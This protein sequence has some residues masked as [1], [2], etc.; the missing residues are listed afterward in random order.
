MAQSNARS[1]FTPAVVG[2]GEGPVESTTGA[3][4]NI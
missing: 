2:Y 1:V 4:F 3:K